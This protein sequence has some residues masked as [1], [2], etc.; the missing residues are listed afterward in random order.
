MHVGQILNDHDIDSQA[1]GMCDSVKIS[2]SFLSNEDASF[3]SL[4]NSIVVTCNQY[5]H[6][7]KL[8]GL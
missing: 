7:S 5:F 6:P 2:D 4:G 1:S 8:L 3:E